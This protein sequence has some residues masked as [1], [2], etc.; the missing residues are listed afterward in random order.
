MFKLLVHLCWVSPVIWDVG[1][2]CSSY[3][4]IYVE[5]PRLFGMSVSG[6]QVIGASMLSIPGYLGCRYRVFKFL[7]PLGWVS[8]VIWDVGI[9]CSSYSCLYRCVS[10]VIWDVGIRCSSYSCIYVEYPRLFGMS[11]SGVQVIC[12]S[13]LSFP[14][15]LGCRY[16][17]FKLFVLSR[18]SIA[19][20][21]GCR[22][23]VFKL[24]VP[25]GWVSP[26]IWDVGIGCSS[27]SCLYRWV[28]PGYLGCRCLVFKLLV[29]LC[30]VFPGYLGCRYRV[31]K[32]LVPPRCVAWLTDAR[33][34]RSCLNYTTRFMAYMAPSWNE[35][36]S[37]YL[38]LSC[39]LI[40]YLVVPRPAV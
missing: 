9:R 29:H 35:I 6:V 5:F 11:V 16:R 8:P 40:V 24:F 4:C 39:L 36:V 14:G 2:G 10:P 27:Y 13:M 34:P 20:Y 7:V 3:S 18:L 37:G 26:V 31:F 38:A 17:V 21:F 28:F 32:L 12:A 1:I 33:D 25:L 30:W 15:Y 22:Y 19:G 23:R